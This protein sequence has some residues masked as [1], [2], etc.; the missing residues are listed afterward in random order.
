MGFR[1]SARVI[2]A[3]TKGTAIWNVA[4]GEPTAFNALARRIQRGC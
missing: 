3:G 4:G 1:V 2:L